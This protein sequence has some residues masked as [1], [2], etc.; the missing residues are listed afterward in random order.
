MNLHEI[1]Y[2]DQPAGHNFQHWWMSV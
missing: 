2:F 1:L